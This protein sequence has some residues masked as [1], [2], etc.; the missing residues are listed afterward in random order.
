MEKYICK[1]CGKKGTKEELLHH[2]C[3]RGIEKHYEDED[4][5]FLNSLILVGA[6][7]SFEPEPHSSEPEPLEG[8]GGEFSGGGASGD[9]G[10]SESSSDSGDSGGD[11]GGGD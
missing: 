10:E 11:S 6:I 8:G 1:H 4:D 7:T 9:F 2:I 3:K 5:S